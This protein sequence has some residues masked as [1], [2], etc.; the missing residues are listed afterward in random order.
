MQFINLLDYI[1][2]FEKEVIL[3]L[4]V[5]M[6]LK[7]SVGNVWKRIAELFISRTYKL[8]DIATSSKWE[9]WLA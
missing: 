1:L 4:I 3:S 6:I 5:N 2:F 9:I 8:L 7:I